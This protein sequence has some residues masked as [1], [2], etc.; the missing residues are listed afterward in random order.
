MSVGT[1]TLGPLLDL[2]IHREAQGST[3]GGMNG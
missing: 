1:H 3:G 2:H